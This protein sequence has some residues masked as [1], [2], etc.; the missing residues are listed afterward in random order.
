MEARRS[1]S[2]FKSGNSVFRELPV[3]EFRDKSLEGVLAPEREGVLALEVLVDV[4]VDRPYRNRLGSERIVI[5]R[6]RVNLLDL[7]ETL[8]RAKGEPVRW[9][10]RA[11]G[12]SD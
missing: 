7:D 6:F 2:A 10:G 4:V 8:T 5:L 9:G 1:V 11:A 3:A 12:S